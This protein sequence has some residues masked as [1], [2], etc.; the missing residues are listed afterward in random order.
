M[1]AALDDLERPDLNGDALDQACA[2]M[3]T[4]V[5]G[6][7]LPGTL[8]E[9][10]CVCRG[11]RWGGGEGVR[12]MYSH[13]MVSGRCLFEFSQS[14]RTAPPPSLFPP[15]RLPR[16]PL[17][18]SSVFN[19]QGLLAVRSSAN[20]ED[21]AGMSAAGLYESVVG[22]PV[23][24]PEQLRAAAAAVWASLYTRRAVLSRR[25]AGRC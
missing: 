14:L 11:G 13:G 4:L 22:V 6:L 2:R 21:L 17:Q 20:V 8:L 19:G 12:T 1:Q 9:Q 15:D 16:P 25:W 24:K 7:S 10:V 5:A 18:I 3:Q 23:A